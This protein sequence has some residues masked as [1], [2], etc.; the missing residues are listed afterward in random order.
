MKNLERSKNILLD[1]RPIV[2]KKIKELKDRVSKLNNKPKLVIIRIGNDF[3]SGKYVAN[4]IKKCEEVEI[5]S[6][7]IHLE[8]V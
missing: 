5:D 8:E 3:A 4:K 1:A 6:Q 7:I 2:S